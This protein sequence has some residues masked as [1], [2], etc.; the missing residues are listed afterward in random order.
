MGSKNP[1]EILETGGAWP[2]NGLR[3]DEAEMQLSV[4]ITS[5]DLAIKAAADMRHEI[6]NDEVHE[7][8][9]LRLAKSFEARLRGED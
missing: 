5:L 8:R 2:P 9:I 4:R 6:D 3:Y 7:R 1:E